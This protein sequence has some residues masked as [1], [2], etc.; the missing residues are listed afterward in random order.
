MTS[1]LDEHAIAALAAAPVDGYGVGTALVT[2]SGAPAAGLVYKLVARADDAGTMIGVAKVSK[3][4]LSIAGRKW[5]VRRRGSTG[6]A[7]TEV[8]GIGG[9]PAG[10]DRPLL[11]E[12]VRDGAVVGREP[13]GAARERHQAAR[14]ELPPSAFK[15]SRGE[16]AIPTVYELEHG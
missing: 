4:K 11:V 13:L 15:L 1:D 8:V 12:L 6:I 3:D 9:E 10:D 5:A 2:G 16:P 7:E 14:A